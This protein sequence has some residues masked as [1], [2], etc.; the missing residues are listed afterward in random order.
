MKKNTKVVLISISLLILLTALFLFIRT[1]SQ[2]TKQQEVPQQT[3]EPTVQASPENNS[4]P[5]TDE[6]VKDRDQ[7]HEKVENI[8]DQ[9]TRIVVDRAPGFWDKVK[10]TGNWFMEFDTKY[11]L[12]LLGVS[13]LIFS[14][15]GG[16][17]SRKKNKR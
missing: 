15:V 6:E 9:A 4:P 8:I 5:V 12:I 16:E 2:N 11:A 10:N 3:T 13:V 14:V 7:S 17:G 1:P